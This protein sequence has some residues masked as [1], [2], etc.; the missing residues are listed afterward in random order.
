MV[1]FCRSKK[2]HFLLSFLSYFF[3]ADTIKEFIVSALRRRWVRD[4]R[5]P[6]VSSSNEAATRDS[7]LRSRMTA[8]GGAVKDLGRGFFVRRKPR[9]M[10]PHASRGSK[11]TQ[12]MKRKQIKSKGRTLSCQRLP[13]VKGA[14]ERKRD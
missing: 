11:E 14:V 9:D 2:L 1:A 13:C 12:P 6:P 10:S 8:R 7:S 3:S 4:I 5:T